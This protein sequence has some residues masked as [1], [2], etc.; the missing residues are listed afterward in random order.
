MQKQTI[1]SSASQYLAWGG[2]KGPQA[3]TRQSDVVPKMETSHAGTPF[4]FDLCG[5]D[6]MSL[7]VTK[8]K[9]NFHKNQSVA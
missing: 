7:I 3:P 5:Y 4:L 9:H 8:S 2:T 6:T 1:R